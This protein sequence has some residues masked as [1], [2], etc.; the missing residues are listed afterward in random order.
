MKI[1]GPLE[2]YAA[3]KQM[4]EQGDYE[5][6]EVG[7]PAFLPGTK[8]PVVKMNFAMAGAGMGDHICYMPGMIWAAKNVPYIKGRIWVARFMNQMFK[9]LMRDFPTWT[10]NPIED[11]A[12]GMEARTVL[13]GVG[14]THNGMKAPQHLNGCGTHLVNV[15]FA[16]LNQ[17]PPPEGADVMPQLDFSIEEPESLASPIELPEKY[18][19]FTTGGTVPARTVPGEYWNPIIDHAIS[20]GYMPV[21]LGTTRVAGTLD[22]EFPEGCDYHKGINLINKTSIMQAAWIMR[23]AECVLGLDNGLIYVASCTDADIVCGYNT[24]HP[25]ERRPK[26]AGDGKWEEIYLS[27]KDLQCSSCQTDMELLVVHSFKYCFYGHKRCI[28]ILFS[29]NG[30]RWTDAIDRMIDSRKFDQELEGL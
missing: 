21:F 24:V 9:N 4:I 3:T 13:R 28:D 10:V 1:N 29:D 17:N 14:I 20:R 26:R 15:G 22:V 23:N 27:K 12:T 6:V 8:I 2:L 19:V 25:R 16:F 7:A 18:I 11:I 5:E 30:R